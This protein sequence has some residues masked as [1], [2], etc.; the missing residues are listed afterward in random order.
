MSVPEKRGA[1]KNGPQV[2]LILDR[3]AEV[4]AEKG[5]GQSGLRAIALDSSFSPA[6]VYYYFHSKEE[7]LFGIVQRGLTRLLSAING[8]LVELD[9]SFDRLLA[10]TSATISYRLNHFDEFRVLYRESE[11]LTGA[12]RKA[13]DELR[14]VYL[15]RVNEV[16]DVYIREHVPEALR[17]SGSSQDA[18][19]RQRRAYYLVG[20]TSWTL[21]NR[22]RAW[23]SR[24]ADLDEHELAAEICNVFLNGV[25]NH[26]P[27]SNTAMA[28]PGRVAHRASPKG[29]K[30]SD[31]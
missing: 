31:K 14:A 27:E 6:R 15:S 3:A 2:D 26:R 11:V 18:F 10:I 9:S 30:R 7:L 16:V 25:V 1:R 12:Y 19:W 29:R 4:I 8:R 17:D 20:L 23:G 22:E 28:P 21:M 13:A 24:A 5:Y